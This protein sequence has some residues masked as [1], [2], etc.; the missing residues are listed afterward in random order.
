M[1]TDFWGPLTWTTLHCLTYNYP[2]KPNRET[3]KKTFYFFNYIIPSILPCPK[4]QKHFLKQLR[5]N[6][7]GDRL[8]NR[9]SLC[10]WLIEIHNYVNSSNRKRMYSID[11]VNQIYQNRIYI[12]DIQ[13]LVFFLRSRVQYG[14]LSP[15]WYNQFIYYLNILLLRKVPTNNCGHVL[16]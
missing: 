1:S 7:I 10:R 3:R 13:K 14:S 9:E 2:T 5:N 11:E 15:N 16:T 12:N 8:D 6:P 4:C